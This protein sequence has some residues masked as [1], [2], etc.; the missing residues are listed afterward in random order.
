MGLIDFVFGGN[1]DGNFQI[2][3]FYESFLVLKFYDFIVFEEFIDL[4]VYFLVN[5][6]MFVVLFFCYL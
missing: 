4:D 1:C 6:G 3:D 2:D 5:F